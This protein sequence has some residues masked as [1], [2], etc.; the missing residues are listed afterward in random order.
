MPIVYASDD[1]ADVADVVAVVTIHD[2]RT[3]TA[4]SSSR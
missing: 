1:E 3:S 2:G 4:A